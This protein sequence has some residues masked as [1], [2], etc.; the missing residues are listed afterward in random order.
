M[1]ITGQAINPIDFEGL[2]IHD[3]TEGMDLSSSLAKIVV[4]PGVSHKKA[5]SKKSDKYYYVVS[6]KLQFIVD[7]VSY[8]LEAGDVC[9]IRKGQRFSYH[10]LSQDKA[11]LLLVHTPM[12]DIESEVFEDAT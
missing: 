12:F 10:N 5:W 3:Y 1:K 6:G 7:D 2:M 4:A 8:D 11:N 9:L